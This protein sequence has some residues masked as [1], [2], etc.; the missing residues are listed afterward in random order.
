MSVAWKW[1]SHLA[2]ACAH[3]RYCTGRPRWIPNFGP[4]CVVTACSL[5]RI[6]TLTVNSNNT[7]FLFDGFGMMYVSAVTVYCSVSDIERCC[8]SHGSDQ[9]WTS[10]VVGP[11]RKGWT[12][13]PIRTSS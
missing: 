12:T 2:Q 6:G 13:F 11:Y 1:S 9:R 5:F 4:A 3:S 7:Q 10:N 8:V